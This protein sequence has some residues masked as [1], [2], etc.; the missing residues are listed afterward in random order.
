MR[1]FLLF[2]GCLTLTACNA[3]AGIREPVEVVTEGGED[4]GTSP[5]DA[6]SSGLDGG[7][8]EQDARVPPG[9]GFVGTWSPSAPASGEIDC[10]GVKSSPPTGATYAMESAGPARLRLSI[11]GSGCVFLLTEV[12]AETA[13][14]DANQSCTVQNVR[15]T[16]ESS[17][18]T[19]LSPTTAKLEMTGKASTPQCAYGTEVFLTK[20]I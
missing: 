1:A 6:P 5:R 18:V 4:G 11:S 8:V 16:F 20:S 19:L 13:E 14:F 15:Y 2:V 3:L 17:K 7:P 10:D 12:S 9:P